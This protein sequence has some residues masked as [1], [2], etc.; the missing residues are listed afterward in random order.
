MPNF[1]EEVEAAVIDDAAL[2]Q[3]DTSQC[4]PLSES[5]PQAW[6]PP[7]GRNTQQFPTTVVAITLESPAWSPVVPTQ[8]RSACPQQDLCSP[9]CPP[10]TSPLA[11]ICFFQ[12]KHSHLGFLFPPLPLHSQI[13]PV[14]HCRFVSPGT[15]PIPPLNTCAIVVRNEQKNVLPLHLALKLLHA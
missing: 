9:H 12:S 6:V 15:L 1:F 8:A 5:G 4:R 14:L 10:C 2:S 3:G 7:P 11:L 13:L